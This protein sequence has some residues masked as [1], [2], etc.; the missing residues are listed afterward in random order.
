MKLSNL[1]V[2]LVIFFSIV[3]SI[4]ISTLIWDKITLPLNNITGAKGALT[5]I[6][7]NPNNDTIRYIFFISFP[8]IVFLFLNLTLKKKVIKI[9]ELIFEKCNEVNKNDLIIIILALKGVP[10]SCLNSMHQINNCILLRKIWCSFQLEF[11]H[12]PGPG[13]IPSITRCRPTA[14]R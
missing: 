7:Y 4:L 6:G 2:N 14:A 8:L 1:Q 3:I 11:R 13:Y 5:E 12:N 10:F 9:N